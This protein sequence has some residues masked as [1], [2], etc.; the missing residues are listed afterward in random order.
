MT[1]VK[2]ETKVKPG[3]KTSLKVK[4]E[5]KVKPKAKV[6]TKAV[7]TGKAH[8]IGNS[9]LLP[10]VLDAKS[11]GV[12]TNEL[13]EM[14]MLIADKYSR[15]SWFVGYSFREDMVAAAVMNLYVNG[16]KFDPDKSNNPFAYFT[17]CC[18]NSFFQFMHEENRHRSIRDT[19]LLD[20]GSAPS[21][22]FSGDAHDE[23]MESRAINN[24]SPERAAEL[25]ANYKHNIVKIKQE[26]KDKIVVE[27]DIPQDDLD[28][29]IEY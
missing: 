21:N 12:V 7:A 22:N 4:T 13:V 23:Y 10:A 16:L 8:Y 26:E 2:T 24:I 18:H 15:K 9:V 19:L 5:P 1:K 28:N 6:K 27:E 3:P 11:K 29:L 17:Q 25:I 20:Y 14:F